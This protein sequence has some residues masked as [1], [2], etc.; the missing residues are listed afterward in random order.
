MANLIY[1]PDLNPVP[2]YEVS[3]AVFDE[4]LTKWFDSYPFAETIYPWQ[5][6]TSYCQKFQQSDTIKIQ[7]QSNFD[8]LQIDLIDKYG[9]V[10]GSLVGNLTLPNVYLPGFFAREF[11]YSLA[12]TPEGVYHLRLTTGDLSVLNMISEPIHVSEKHPHTKLFQYRNTRFHGDVIFETG[13]RFNFRVECDFDAEEFASDNQLYKNQKNSAVLLSARPYDL[14]PL[15]Y[16][17]SKGLPTWAIKKA[18]LIWCVNSVQVDGR[19]M[20]R[21]EEDDP[22]YGKIDGYPMRS[23]SIVVTPGINRQSK[24]VSPTIDTTKKIIVA[25]NINTLLFGDTSS[26]AGSNLVPI[27]TAG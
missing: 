7:L 12:G 27:N 11:T 20:C 13:I 8:P 14:Y 9:A 21:N 22:A 5:Q 17:G 4:Y 25:Y 3:P 16:G 24:I 26:N 2:F 23:M 19:E 10:V 15:V 18:A 1:I 6:R